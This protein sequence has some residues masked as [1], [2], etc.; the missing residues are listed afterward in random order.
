[1]IEVKSDVVKAIL[2]RNLECLVHESRQIVNGQT[3]DGKSECQHFQ[4]QQT[5]LDWNK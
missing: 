3:G 1:M 2:H 5:K 4:N